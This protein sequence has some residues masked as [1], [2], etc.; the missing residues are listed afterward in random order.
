MATVL[1]T[2]C[3]T[4]WRRP[5]MIAALTPPDIGNVTSHAMT[6]LRKMDQSTFSRARNRPTNTT[7]PTLQC[8][9]LMGT[10]TFEATSTVSAE[11]ISIQNPLQ[12]TNNQGWQV[13]ANS[14]LNRS[15][16]HP[17]RN[18]FLPLFTKHGTTTAALRLR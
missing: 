5:A 17:G 7:E 15:L 13:S 9:V 14:S 3:Q 6:I 11:P 16:N 12:Q 18:R 1:W 4:A 10:P 8:V 2:E